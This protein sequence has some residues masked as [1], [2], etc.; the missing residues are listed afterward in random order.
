MLALVRLL[1]DPDNPIV[2]VLAIL[3]AVGLP[4]ALIFLMIRF[5]FL[6]PLIILVLGCVALGY[7][8]WCTG[9]QGAVDDLLVWSAV[10]GVILSAPQLVRTLNRSPLPT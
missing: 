6:L 9:L 8:V 4:A 7:V 5:L 2:V 1:P 3:V 10:I